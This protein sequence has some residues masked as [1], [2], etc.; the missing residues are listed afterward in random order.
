[1][2]TP[3]QL[4]PV[5]LFRIIRLFDELTV[6]MPDRWLLVRELSSMV[7]WELPIEIPWPFSEMMFPR[8]FVNEAVGFAR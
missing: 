1:M 5:T 8:T 6:R 4:F 7:F 3:I 2:N